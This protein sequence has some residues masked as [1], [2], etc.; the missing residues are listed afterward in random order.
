VVVIGVAIGGNG[1]IAAPSVE[2]LAL[3]IDL[4]VVDFG[5]GVRWI[6]KE[7]VEGRG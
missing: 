3:T 1:G 5:F 7:V 6:G 4:R 2:E